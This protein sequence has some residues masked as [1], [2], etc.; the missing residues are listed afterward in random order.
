MCKESQWPLHSLKNLWPCWS[1]G[2]AGH[3]LLSRGS[4][5]STASLGRG[6]A[7]TSFRRLSP[8]RDARAGVLWLTQPWEHPSYKE[9][10]VRTNMRGNHQSWKRRG[11]GLT[12]HPPPDTHGQN[13]VSRAKGLWEICPTGT[14]APQESLHRKPALLVHKVLQVL[15]RSQA[16]TVSSERTRKAQSCRKGRF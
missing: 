15:A 8:G 1:P 7:E 9:Q 16:F 3:G 13:A 11:R 10:A 2:V 6:V 5:F 4:T 12:S 14:W